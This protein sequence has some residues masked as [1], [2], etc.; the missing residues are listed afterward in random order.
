MFSYKNYIFRQYLYVIVYIIYF[1]YYD[2]DVFIDL[3]VRMP[4]LSFVF[5]KV[6]VSMLTLTFV[7]IKVK[8]GM[9]TL[10]F[11]FID[12]KVGMLT[13]TFVF[14]YLYIYVYGGN[15]SESRDSL[16]F[17]RTIIYY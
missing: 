11:V 15:K 8:V 9:L 5:I 13:L 7:F 10:S 1:K 12:L 16:I 4:T 3:K 17:F 14:I 2:D 6:K